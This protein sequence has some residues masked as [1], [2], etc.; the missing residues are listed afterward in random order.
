MNTEDEFVSSLLNDLRTLSAGNYVVTAVRQSFYVCT[1]CVSVQSSNRCISLIIP[2]AGNTKY[3]ISATYNNGTIDTKKF[4]DNTII[5]ALNSGTIGSNN[6]FTATSN[7]AQFAALCTLDGTYSIYVTDTNGN[8]CYG[9]FT[10]KYRVN[11]NWNTTAN[12]GIIYNT[13]NVFGTI[14]FSGGTAP[15]T[16]YVVRQ[17]YTPSNVTL[18][19]L[20]SSM[21]T[22]LESGD[23]NNLTLANGATNRPPR[24]YYGGDLSQMA[25]APA[26]VASNTSPWSIELVPLGKNYYTKQILHVWQNLSHKAEITYI[27]YQSYASGAITW[28][29]WNRVPTGAEIDSLNSRLSFRLPLKFMDND[30][31]PG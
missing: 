13:S 1:V 23:F 22:V 2:Q 21:S 20:N 10:L 24:L 27:R 9:Q 5:D 8:Y 4:Y 26:E 14:V 6:A 31:R 25:N 3:I 28:T 15:Y 17:T 12:S 29:D 16:A 11:N 18:E 19:K 30:K 7:S